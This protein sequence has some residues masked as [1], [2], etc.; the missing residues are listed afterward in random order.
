MALYQLHWPGVWQNEAYW[1]GLAQCYEQGLVKSVGVSNYGPEQLKKIYK[2]L[3]SRNIPLATNQ[4]QYSLLNRDPESNGILRTARELNVTILA[5]SPLAQG[6]L[7]GKYNETYLPTGSRSTLAK[8][9]VPKITNLISVLKE[10]ANTRDKTVSQVALNWCIA[11]G[12]VPIPGVRS[13]SQA[14][15][16]AGALGWLLDDDEVIRLDTA[17][18]LSGATYGVSFLQG[19]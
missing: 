17:A 9:V 1:D 11:K 18:R 2:V 5:Y 14:E 19:K 10:I 8:S 7:T 13:L 16:N 12:T 3:K 4:I 15:D 6:L